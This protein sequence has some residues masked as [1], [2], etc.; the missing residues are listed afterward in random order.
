MSGDGTEHDL[1]RLHDHLNQAV[2]L[3][4]TRLTTARP[5]VA[6]LLEQYTA[7]RDLVAALRERLPF[8]SAAERE[9]L[10]LDPDLK[11]LSFHLGEEVRAA[12]RRE[13]GS[14]ADLARSLSFLC[15]HLVR[16][17]QEHVEPRHPL[18]APDAALVTGLARLTRA[19]FDVQFAAAYA[20]MGHRGPFVDKIYRDYRLEGLPEGLV[21]A[22]E[23]IALS[24]TYDLVVCVLRGGLPLALLLELC[25]Y[26]TG[27]L[28]HV[29]CTRPSGSHLD[30]S[31]VYRPLDL[32]L[33]DVRGRSVLV[34][35]NNVA[36]GRT[37]ARVTRELRAG[38]PARLDAFADYMLQDL[39]GVTP[40]SLVT[41]AG[42]D[43]LIHGPFE[44]RLTGRNEA[45]ARTRALAEA[46]ARKLEVV[47]PPGARVGE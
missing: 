37:L 3:I 25:G 19:V 45:G 28:R 18:L 35:D 36:R 4:A 38:R 24:G 44:R 29:V 7:G 15:R 31:L 1:R 11:Q 9:R 26:P 2:G 47:A 21:A 6:G 43:A 5:E 34:V 14:D 40:A 46:I 32:T 42:L 33:E 12:R 30:P 20:S 16:L 39:A 27:R 13:A 10:E 23:E 17:G 22:I 8:L 41:E